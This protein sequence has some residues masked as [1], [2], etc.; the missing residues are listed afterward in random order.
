MG[1]NPAPLPSFTG[2]A[3]STLL[4]ARQPCSRTYAADSSFL[5][6][7]STLGESSARTASA[8]W[9]AV[10]PPTAI[11]P[12]SFRGRPTSEEALM[13]IKDIFR[14]PIERTIEEVIKVD[15]ADEET[16]AFELDE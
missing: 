15:L 3:R 11:E 7:C 10:S 9:I 14:R 2:R 13:K 8:S 12:R 16:V 1:P 5:S 6:P 4:T